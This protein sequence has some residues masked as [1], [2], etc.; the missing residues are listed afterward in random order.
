[1][2]LGGY[3]ADAFGC[4]LEFGILLTY[5]ALPILVLYLGCV[6]SPKP[7]NGLFFGIIRKVKAIFMRIFNDWRLLFAAI[8]MI[9]IMYYVYVLYI[10]DALG[11]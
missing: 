1:V 11:V 3:I 5:T 8:A 4:S 2:V 6:V 7:T 9:I 10:A